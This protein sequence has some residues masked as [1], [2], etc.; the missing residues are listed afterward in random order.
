MCVEYESHSHTHTH[1]Y[2]RKW[3]I[4]HIQNSIKMH[5]IIFMIL[6]FYQPCFK[7][8]QGGQLHLSAPVVHN[9]STHKWHKK[10]MACREMYISLLFTPHK[11]QIIWTLRTCC[12]CCPWKKPRNKSISVLLLWAC[13]LAGRVVISQNDSSVHSPVNLALHLHILLNGWFHAGLAL[14]SIGLFRC[15]QGL[16]DVLF[17]S[18]QGHG[19]DITLML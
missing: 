9:T 6:N 19:S 15:S 8:S 4:T 3:K 12:C 10:D 13:Q 14:Q 17:P 2:K 7:S 11:H 1:T 18:S 16:D 5:K